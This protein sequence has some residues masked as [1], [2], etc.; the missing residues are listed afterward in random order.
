MITQT[1]AYKDDL[2][3][4]SWIGEVVDIEDPQKIGRVRVKVYGKFDEIPDTDIPWAYPGN[5]QFSGSDSGGSSFSVPK[6]GSIVSV[7]FDSG[8]IYHPEYFFHQKISDEVKEEISESYSNA[9]VIVYDTVTE[10][11]LK[12]F[13]TESKGLMLDYKTSQIN[14]K[15][16]KSIIIQTASKNSIV[17]LLDDGTLNVIQANDINITTKKAVNLTATNDVT[18][19]CKNLIVDHSSSI[20]LG[21]GASE[22]VILGD[23]F[24]A[25]FNGHI[26]TTPNGPSG[27]PIKPMT[28]S[29]L[30]GKEVKTK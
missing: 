26:H 15:P 28:K 18:V 22:H 8:N 9:H 3:N 24:M 13:F 5:I 11:A 29:L 27:S 1:N 7:K 16:D 12:I 30:S 23:S 14:I 6:K 4:T 25:Y 20:E 21:A 17:E 19:K 2:M 10:G